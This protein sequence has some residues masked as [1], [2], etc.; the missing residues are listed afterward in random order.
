MHED[1]KTGGVGVPNEIEK[2][3]ECATFVVAVERYLFD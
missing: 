1:S 2:H 3:L